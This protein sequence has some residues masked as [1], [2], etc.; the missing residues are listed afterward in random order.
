MVLHDGYLVRAVIRGKK[1]LEEICKGT[2]VM[3][4]RP[5]VDFKLKIRSC[6]WAFVHGFAPHR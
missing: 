2:L 6:P 5:G 1:K 4:D 3:P